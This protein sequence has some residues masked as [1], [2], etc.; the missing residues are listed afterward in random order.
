MREVVWVG[1][2]AT[3]TVWMDSV[4]EVVATVVVV[5]GGGREEATF[6]V[7]LDLDLG[8]FGGCVAIG[9]DLDFALALDLDDVFDF[10]FDLALVEG[11]AVGCTKELEVP[12][13]AEEEAEVGI[14]AEGDVLFCVSRVTGRE[15]VPSVVDSG[16]GKDFR[17]DSSA[18]IASVFMLPRMLTESKESTRALSG[19]FEQQVTK[20]RCR[21]SRLSTEM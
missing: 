21:V 16:P 20:L 14:C 2:A 19:V 12:R 10:N 7:A 3:G 13:D 15:G 9:A 8:G 5:C 6:G 11:S 1:M 18:S 4:A 17:V